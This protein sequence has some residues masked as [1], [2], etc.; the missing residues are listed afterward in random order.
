[1]NIPTTGF[2]IQADD[3]DDF[4]A[5]VSA[6]TGSGK[7]SRRVLWGDLQDGAA[8]VAVWKADCGVYR[9]AGRRY[10][11]TF[12]VCEGTAVCTLGDAPPADIGV[13]AIVYVPADVPIVL[14]VVSPFRKLT[15]AVLQSLLTR[16]ESH[17]L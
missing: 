14:K 10:A 3:D 4:A 6:E 12:V 11:E 15:I 16:R 1:M 9:A 13:G 5:S 7:S 17:R 8:L 2:I